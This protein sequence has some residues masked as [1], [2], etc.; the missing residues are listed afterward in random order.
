MTAMQQRVTVGLFQS[1][2]LAGKYCC[3]MNIINEFI[4]VILVVFM[5]GILRISLDILFESCNIATISISEAPDM[6]EVPLTYDPLAFVLIIFCNIV[7]VCNFPRK[8]ILS[9]QTIPSFSQYLE[10]IHFILICCSPYL[11]NFSHLLIPRSGDIELN[12]GPVNLKLC[13][14][15]I[16]S[17]SLVKLLAIRQEIAE[18]FNIITLSET[19]LNRKT[20]H[21][22]EIPGFHPICRRVRGS[23]G[24]GVACY[25][26][27][28]LVA[29]RRGD[30]ESTDMEYL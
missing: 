19:L 21:N 4:D 24:G 22:L 1:R 15:N 11:Y 26:G 7:P 2:I 16:R 30:L 17:L 8:S 25:V 29:K 13:H 3:E 10:G 28:N 20:S 9:R 6:Y 27:S 14:I 23:F 18:K 12:L 5:C